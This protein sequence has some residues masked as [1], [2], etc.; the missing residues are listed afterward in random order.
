MSEK[1]II[2]VIEESI[3]GGYEAKALGYSIFA[4]G[5]DIEDLKLQI[6]DAV[7]CHFEPTEVP[8]VIRLH[9]IREEVIPA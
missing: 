7:K 1:E 9:W 2:F 6:R 5:D 3:D 4:Q 8:K